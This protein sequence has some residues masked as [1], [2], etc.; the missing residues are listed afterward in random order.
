M[1]DPH[2]ADGFDEGVLD[3]GVELRF[4]GCEHLRGHPQVRRTHLV[5][6]L[7]QLAQR[8]GPVMAHLLAQRAHD[9][10]GRLDVE[11]RTR[12]RIAQAACIEGGQG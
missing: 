4:G 9:V 5:E 2:A 3:R 1:D 12:Q 8:V 10:E 7:P 6:S 11:L